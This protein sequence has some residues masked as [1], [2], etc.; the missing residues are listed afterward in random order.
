MAA[1]RSIHK[2]VPSI[3]SKYN[4]AYEYQMQEEVVEY[5]CSIEKQ[6]GCRM[7]AV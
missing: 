5:G 7:A 4:E 6:Y 1:M 3:Y 2:V